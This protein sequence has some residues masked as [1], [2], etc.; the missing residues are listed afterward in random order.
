MQGARVN[1]YAVARK[2]QVFGIK[3]RPDSDMMGGIYGFHFGYAHKFYDIGASKSSFKKVR[4]QVSSD[5]TLGGARHIVCNRAWCLHVFVCVPPPPPSFS[6][7]KGLD[8]LASDLKPYLLK[9]E[10]DTAWAVLQAA[11]VS[12]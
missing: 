12:E 8:E 1:K 3:L 9:I 6:V 7:H 10:E 4:S 11:K 5:Y 2:K